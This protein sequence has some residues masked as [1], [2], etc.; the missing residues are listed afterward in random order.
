M[1]MIF[2]VADVLNISLNSATDSSSFGGLMD[3]LVDERNLTEEYINWY[4]TTKLDTVQIGDR[5]FND[6]YANN[7][8]FYNY[9]FGLVAFLDRESKLWVYDRIE[10][11]E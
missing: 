9:A 4:Q 2:L 7:N 5:T 1:E 11:I 3:I 10:E 8:V 6:V